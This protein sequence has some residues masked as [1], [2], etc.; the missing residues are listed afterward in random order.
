MYKGGTGASTGWWPSRWCWRAS[1]RR[2]TQELRF[3]LEAELAARVQ[4]PNI[5][6]VYEIGSYD[7]RPFLC[8]RVGRGRQP[9][10]PAGRQARPAGEA[11]RLI[12]T[13]AHATQAAHGEGVIH[14]DLK[15]ANIL[16]HEHEAS[17]TMTGRK[18]VEPARIHPS[19]FT[20]RRSQDHRLRTRPADRGRHDLDAERLPGRTPGYMAP[21][22]AAGKRATSGR[23]RTFTPWGSCST[24]S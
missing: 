8:S 18:T 4:H 12:E 7:G 16:L 6:Q 24:S 9:G 20:V 21:E 15:P 2:S 23:R 22:Q 14:R 10:G 13:L 11:A 1:S 19:S 17:G 5:V 3:R